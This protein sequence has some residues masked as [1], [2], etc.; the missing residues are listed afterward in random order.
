MRCSTNVLWFPPLAPTAVHAV[1]PLHD[2]AP[3]LSSGVGEAFGLGTID[4]T[5]PSHDSIKVQSTVPALENPTAK[6]ADGPLHDTPERTSRWVG[7]VLALATID[8]TDPFHDSISVCCVK[9]PM[10]Y[11][12][13][14]KQ[15]DG[16]LHDTPLR[17]LL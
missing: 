11:A 17:T 10:A 12:P 2:T 6:Q 8:H 5:D 7:E 15:A 13:T 1:G 3:R 4:H 14:A 9:A 16:P